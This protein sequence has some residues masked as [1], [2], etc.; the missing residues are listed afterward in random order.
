MWHVFYGGEIEKRKM[1]K[2][3]VNCKTILFR[4]E[5][6]N[7][8]WFIFRIYK[9]FCRVQLDQ[10]RFSYWNFLIGIFVKNMPLSLHYLLYFFQIDLF[11][12]IFS[13]SLFSDFVFLS[14]FF[15]FH[16]NQKRWG[17]EI[18]FATFTYFVSFFVVKQSE[19]NCVFLIVCVCVRLCRVCLRK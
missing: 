2:I 6:K 19:V 15:I 14:H 4:F 11:Y 17:K 13:I 5:N 16:A 10:L 7:E 18:Y 8:I 9:C 1:Q 3:H 12:V